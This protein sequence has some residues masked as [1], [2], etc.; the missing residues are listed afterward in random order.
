M[1]RQRQRP[2]W[3]TPESAESQAPPGFSHEFSH[4]GRER[5]LNSLPEKRVNRTKPLGQ[6][7]QKLTVVVDTAHQCTDL[8]HILGIGILINA[9]TFCAF[10]RRPA[11]EME[12]LRNFASVAPNR[13]FEGGSMRL[14]FRRRS[15]RERIVDMRYRIEIEHNDIVEVCRHLF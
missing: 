3:G 11:G 13:A 14:C 9:D 15:K 2:N 7:G 5:K 10:G 6:V 4:S 8:L 1:S 12:W